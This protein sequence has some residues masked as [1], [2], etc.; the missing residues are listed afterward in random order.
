MIE[1][2]SFGCPIIVYATIMPDLTRF[3]AN[4]LTYVSLFSYMHVFH[5]YE[6]PNLRYTGADTAK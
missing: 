2:A 5:G 1:T 3:G 6:G 4:S